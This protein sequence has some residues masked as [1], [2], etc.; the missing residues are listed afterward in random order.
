MRTS[1]A[2]CQRPLEI[3]S[4]EGLLDQPTAQPVSYNTV[5]ENTLFEP[6]DRRTMRRFGLSSRGKRFFLVRR[7]LNAV[8]YC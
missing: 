6:G 5:F 7:Y 1:E 3:L 4:T 8:A 2:F